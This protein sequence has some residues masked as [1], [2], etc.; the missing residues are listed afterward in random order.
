MEQKI[1]TIVGGTGFVGRYVVKRLAKAGWRIR[2]IAR[3]PD[4]ARHLRTAGEV[5]QVVLARGNLADPQSLAGKIEDSYAV[6]NLVGVLFESGKQKFTALHAQGA[7]TLAQM[8]Y[9]SGVKRFIQ[10]SAL[11]VDKAGGSEYARTKL[12]GEKAVRAAFPA[13]TILRPSVIFGPEDNF[14]N[15][16]A[17]M[18]IAAPALP[19][20]GGGLT[21]FQA[22]YV[23]DVAKA[24]EA[25]LT[26]ADT[27]G[28]TYELGGPHVYTFKEILQ[29]ILKTVGR[30]K[31]LVTVPFPV[32]SMMGSVAQLLPRP[33]LTRDQVALL[34]HDNIVGPNTKTFAQLG[35]KPA[36][37]EVIVPEYLAR[38]RKANP[39]AA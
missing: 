26:R 32:A 37:V 21:R 34:R 20:I 31:P 16:F 5:G 39:V 15:Q 4:A 13:A 1:V 17:A 14:F 27:P 33:L 38:F 6:V 7:E 3:N 12:V 36:A 30:E 28:Q 24:I 11:G 10:I 8:A 22:V 9:A 25:C 2:I 35:I 19:L 29:F 18:S 23:G